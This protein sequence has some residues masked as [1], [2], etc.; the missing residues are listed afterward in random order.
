MLKKKLKLVKKQRKT[1]SKKAQKPV[2]LTLGEQAEAERFKTFT[3]AKASLQAKVRQMT[4]KLH[5]R[6]ESTKKAA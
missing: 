6:N 4:R 1:T 3:K 2:S 5:R